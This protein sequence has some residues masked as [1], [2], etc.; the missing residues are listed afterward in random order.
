MRA[1]GGVG[2]GWVL[3]ALALAQRYVLLPGLVDEATRAAMLEEAE[4]VPIAAW[5]R[6]FNAERPLADPGPEDYSEARQMAMHGGAVAHHVLGKWVSDV[7]LPRVQAAR[8]AAYP[9]VLFGYVKTCSDRAQHPHR[10]RGAAG[11]LAGV[12]PG[13]P[14]PISAAALSRR[15][16][17]CGRRSSP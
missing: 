3:V 6:I 8:P 12:C 1:R 9:H 17:P 15:M 7:L 4:A 5:R 10:A 13:P 11:T 2:S 16:P 14:P